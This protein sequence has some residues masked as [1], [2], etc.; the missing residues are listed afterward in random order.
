M[1]VK[2]TYKEIKKKINVNVFP[3]EV[4]VVL[5]TDVNEARKRRNKIFGETSLDHAIAMH[6]SLH[7]GF[8]YLFLP[9]NCTPW[10]LCHEV[11]HTVWEIMHFIGAELE[12]EVMAYLMSFLMKEINKFGSTWK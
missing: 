7:T 12:N 3:Y 9:Y 5:T 8:S 10:V 6:S 4:Y 2:P 1:K 11:F